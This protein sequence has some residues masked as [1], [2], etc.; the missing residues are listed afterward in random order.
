MSHTDR[1]DVIDVWVT[2]TDMVRLD[3]RVTAPVSVAHRTHASSQSRVNAYGVTLLLITSI[4]IARL[5]EIYL[6]KK[7]LHKFISQNI[8]KK[9]QNKKNLF[10]RRG[11]LVPHGHR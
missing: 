3:W 11:A 5:K 4:R 10:G 1:Y 6:E 2:P 7:V 8:V 9:D